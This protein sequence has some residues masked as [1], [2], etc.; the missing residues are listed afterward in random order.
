MSPE[1]W[2]AAFA[3]AS[4][5]AAIIT[6]TV[7]SVSLMGARRDSRD[8]SR[9]LVV[10]SLRKGPAMSFGVVYLVIENTG[11]SLARDIQVTFTPPLPNYEKTADG[12]RGVVAPFLRKRYGD[13]LAILAP[14]QR[15]SNVYSYVAEGIDGNVEPMPDQLSVSL[16]Y[17]DDHGRHYADTFHLDRGNLGLETRA[18]PSED[19]DAVRRRNQALEAIAWE[20]WD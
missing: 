13:P 17:L 16:E 4:A 7:A 20:L 11:R 3:G 5:L 14:G 6:A 15:L 2:S 8:R 19:N 9:P 1:I 18:N 10:A 12:Q